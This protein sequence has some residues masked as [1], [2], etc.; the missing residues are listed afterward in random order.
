MNLRAPTDLG[1]G[2]TDHGTIVPVS[3]LRGL[4]ATA[5]GA[6]RPVVL[7]WLYDCRGTYALLLIDAETGRSVEFPLPFPVTGC[8]FASL[9]S[10]RNRLYTHSPSPGSP[11][12]QRGEEGRRRPRRSLTEDDAINRE[13]WAQSHLMTVA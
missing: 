6:G 8:P 12:F 10:R 3:D 13:N 7:L 2:F 4:V 9:L 1:L 5:D 11:A